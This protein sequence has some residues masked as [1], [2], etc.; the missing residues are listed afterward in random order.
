MKKQI[1][2]AAMIVLN[3]IFLFFQLSNQSGIAEIIN[4]KGKF[5]PFSLAADNENI[6]FFVTTK[7][8][9][10]KY[11]KYLKTRRL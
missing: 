9:D 5:Y 7:M 6:Y 10:V 11:G 2:I 8:R 4:M 3:L 1:V